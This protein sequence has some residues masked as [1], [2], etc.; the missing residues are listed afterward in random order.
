VHDDA[1]VR[2]TGTLAYT[3]NNIVVISLLY[4]IPQR[5]RSFV[6]PFK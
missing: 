4:K 5:D 3:I 6:I 1:Y 2:K